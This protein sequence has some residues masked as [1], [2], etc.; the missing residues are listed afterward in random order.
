MVPRTMYSNCNIFGKIIIL[1]EKYKKSGEK[2]EKVFI[3]RISFP[4][5]FFYAI[6]EL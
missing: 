3:T 2:Y 4:E 5:A 1:K 6:M